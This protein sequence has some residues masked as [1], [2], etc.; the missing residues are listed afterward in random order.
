[1]K[2]SIQNWTSPNRYIVLIQFITKNKWAA[3]GP[4][5][6]CDS[7]FNSS[8]VDKVHVLR[9]KLKMPLLRSYVAYVGAGAPCG[10]LRACESRARNASWTHVTRLNRTRH[11][12]LVHDYASTRQVA[13]DRQYAYVRDRSRTISCTGMYTRLSDVEL[14]Y[15]RIRLDIQQE[16]VMQITLQLTVRTGQVAYVRDTSRTSETRLER[17]ESVMPSVTRSARSRATVRARRYCS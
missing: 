11:A 2:R 9:Y 17:P 3:S 4:P 5:L 15:K 10:Q 14:Y 7:R 8:L 12:T 6:G 13:C 1:M 16:C